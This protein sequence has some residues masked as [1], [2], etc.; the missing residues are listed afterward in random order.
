M[1]SLRDILCMMVDGEINTRAD[2]DAI[3]GEETP[4]YQAQLR[5]DIES[6]ADRLCTPGASAR[7]K[8]LFERRD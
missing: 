2:A 1:R 8:E 4:E 5:R 7:L 3:L 6:A